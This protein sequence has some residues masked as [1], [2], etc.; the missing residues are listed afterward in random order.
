M[1]PDFNIY[2]VFEIVSVVFLDTLSKT[3]LIKP[4]RWPASVFLR[5][6]APLRDTKKRKLL[7]APQDTKTP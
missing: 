6:S 3:D 7:Q 1:N 5:A 4:Y 2:T